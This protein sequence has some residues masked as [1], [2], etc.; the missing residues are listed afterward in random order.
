[1]SHMRKLEKD[2]TLANEA[3]YRNWTHRWQSHLDNLDQDGP[4]SCCWVAIFS[5]RSIQITLFNFAN[6][7]G[8]LW[9][10]MQGIH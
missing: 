6:G 3:N 10:F 8:D 1:M 9:R 2:Q 7:M 4:K 5:P